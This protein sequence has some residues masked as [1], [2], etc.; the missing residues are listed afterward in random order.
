MHDL[1]FYEISAGAVISSIVEIVILPRG[2]SPLSAALTSSDHSYQDKN[3]K[4][5]LEGGTNGEEYLITIKIIDSSGEKFESEMVLRVQDLNW[6][7]PEGSGHIYLNPR[8]YVQKF[9]YSET[10]LLC[11]LYDLN[12]IDTAK[13]LMALQ[14]AAALVDGYISAQ[15]LVPLAPVP[16]LITAI[17]GNIARHILH[18]ENI[19]ESVGANYN[20]ALKKLKDIASGILKISGARVESSSSSHAPSYT[21]SGRKFTRK[22]Y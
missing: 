13:I 6:S 1:S 19:P 2:L 18:V 8:E 16:A 21:V 17:T 7:V 10:V 20:Q 9:G 4:F 12:R 22:G 5:T 11:D 15:Y 14:E 3:V